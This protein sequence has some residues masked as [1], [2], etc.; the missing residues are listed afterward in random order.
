MSN[1][2]EAAQKVAKTILDNVE[3]VIFGKRGAISSPSL[4]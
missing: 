4:P 3:L 2:I 1:G